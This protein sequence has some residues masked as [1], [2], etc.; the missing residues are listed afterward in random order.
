MPRRKNYI[1]MQATVKGAF[2]K[3]IF[4]VWF[5]SIAPGFFAWSVPESASISRVGLATTANTREHFESLLKKVGGVVQSRLAGPIP[6]YDPNA[7]AS[8]AEQAIFLVGDAASLVKATTGGGI[9]TGMLS[10]RLAAKA[11]LTNGNYEAMLTPLRRELF[12]HLV[13]RRALNRFSQTDYN[14]LVGL[15]QN[16]KVRDILSSH[17]REFPSR[18][19]FK[20][21]RAEPRLLQFAPR[22]VASLFH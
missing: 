16:K 18:F 5:G 1:G 3:S 4:S 22:C 10:A 21:V 6:L 7:K 11:I 17:P 13:L 15:M 14:A 8:D 20:L 9:I 12:A 2:D 19:L